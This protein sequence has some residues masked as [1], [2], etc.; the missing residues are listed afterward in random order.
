MLFV[1]KKY[2]IPCWKGFSKDLVSS[3]ISEMLLNLG[4]KKLMYFSISETCDEGLFFLCFLFEKHLQKYSSLVFSWF[5]LGS[6]N[7]EEEEKI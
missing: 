6:T 7:F 5:L 2:P 3:E 1:Y 4:K